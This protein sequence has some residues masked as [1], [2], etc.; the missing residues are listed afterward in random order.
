M[1]VIRAPCLV[2]L[3]LLAW[4]F[5]KQNLGAEPETLRLRSGVRIL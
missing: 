1:V 5:S 2:Y 3:K 4:V